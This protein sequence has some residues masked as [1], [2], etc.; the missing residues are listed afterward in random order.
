MSSWLSLCRPGW[1]MRDLPASASHVPPFPAAHTIFRDKLQVEIWFFKDFEKW[2]EE[3]K[4]FWPVQQMKWKGK[5]QSQSCLDL[6]W[7]SV[8]LNIPHCLFIYLGSL[9][10]SLLWSFD[11]PGGMTR[12]ALNLRDPPASAFL[13][14]GFYPS[15]FKLAHR[16]SYVILF[17]SPWKW[18]ESC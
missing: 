17:K 14:L 16:L 1:Q 15:Q 11:C 18:H 13:A 6:Q 9:R 7:L 2:V 5:H 8:S 3:A 10:Q 12:L 4:H